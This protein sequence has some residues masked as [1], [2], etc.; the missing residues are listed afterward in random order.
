MYDVLNILHYLTF[1][2]FRVAS[3]FLPWVN[4]SKRGFLSTEMAQGMGSEEGK[5]LLRVRLEVRPPVGM[6]HRRTAHSGWRGH[7]VMRRR[8][9]IRWDIPIIRRER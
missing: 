5:S 2:M 6:R 9:L 3:L 8:A 1:T 7:S 4:E